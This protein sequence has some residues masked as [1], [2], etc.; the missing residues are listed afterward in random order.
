MESSLG[1]ES[2]TQ[3][4]AATTLRR[5]WASAQVQRPRTTQLLGA[6]A[7]R[8]KACVIVLA[9]LTGAVVQ[10]L[11]QSGDALYFLQAGQQLVGPHAGEVFADSSLQVGPAYLVLLGVLA[12]AAHALHLSAW[13]VI[14]AVQSALLVWALLVAL[15]RRAGTVAQLTV[16]V[17]VVAGGPLYEVLLNGHPEELG[18][19]LLLLLALGESRRAAVVLPSTLVATA[20]TTKLWG[21]LGFV[22]LLATASRG[23]A[24]L[25]RVAQRLVLAGSLVATAYLPFFLWGTVRTFD[26]VWLT[27]RD[28][29]LGAVTGFGGGF[30]LHL[31][32]LQLGS[33]ALVGTVLLLRGAADSAVVV[34][35]VSVRLAL[36]PFHQVY[37]VTDLEVLV[38]LWAWCGGAG[39]RV[40]GA[41][42]V[43][44]PVATVL[45]YVAS[46]HAFAW[47][48]ACGL[49]VLMT[50]AARSRSKRP[51]CDSFATNAPSAAHP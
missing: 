15:P 19:G 50:L 29:V 33:A 46:P 9:A 1:A 5:S 14:G 13:V 4:R 28:S 8:P 34:G 25:R 43:L 38:L 17:V 16:G 23:P 6:L 24:D 36:D 35:A 18:T 22:C 48:E 2:P 44:V 45:P 27:D 39:Q 47:G 10:P 32:A 3:S 51:V 30:G 11:V 20:S 41:T 37:Y 26:F 21:V 31:R 49:V 12:G 42:T 7:A 40:R